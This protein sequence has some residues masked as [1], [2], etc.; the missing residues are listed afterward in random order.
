MNRI[1]TAFAG[2]AAAAVMLA[3]VAASAGTEIPAGGFSKH[4]LVVEPNY[5]GSG[6]DQKKYPVIVMDRS[7]HLQLTR[8]GLAVTGIRWEQWNRHEAEGLGRIGSAQVEVTLYHSKWRVDGVPVIVNGKH[9]R[10]FRDVAIDTAGSK[11]AALMHWSWRAK[12]W[13]DSRR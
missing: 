6:F 8:Q 5:K 12:Q 10:Y 9:Y 4:V 3:P 7:S 1:A 13:V 2:V 11:Q